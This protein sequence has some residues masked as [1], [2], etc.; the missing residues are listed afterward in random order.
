VREDAAN[1]RWLGRQANGTVTEFQKRAIIEVM[2]VC[3]Q[4]KLEGYAHSLI[5]QSIEGVVA[6]ELM[7]L[8]SGAGARPSFF[9]LL[10]STE[11]VSESGDSFFSHTQNE[12]TND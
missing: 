12:V 2:E 11:G 6:S 9:T 3:G 10:E 4:R 5:R 8:T 7:L 1:V